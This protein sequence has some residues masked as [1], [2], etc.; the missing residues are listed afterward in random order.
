MDRKKLSRVV[1]LCA[2]AIPALA[3][4]SSHREA[5]FIAGAP[6]VDGTDFYMFR[7]YEPGRSQ[8]VTFIANYNPLQDAYGGPNYFT[9]DPK[10]LYE[11][12]ID[13]NGDARPD[14]TFQFRFLNTYRALTVD[15]G[16]QKVAVPLINIGPVTPAGANLNVIQTYSIELVRGDPRQ[17]EHAPVTNATLG[18]QTFFKPVDNIGMK[19]IANYPAYAANFIYNIA[20]PGCAEQGRVFV[21]QRKDGFVVNL[22]EIFDLVNLNPLGPRDGEPNI[23]S[24]K[25]V[26]SIALEV[27][28]ACLVRGGDPVIGAWTTASLRQG[29]VLN[30]D[31]DRDDADDGVRIH[32]G[33]WTQVSRLGSPLVNEVVIGLPDKNRFNGSEPSHDTQFLTYVT[34]PTLPVLLNALFGSAAMVPGTPRNDLVTIFLTG[35]QGLNQPQH[36]TPAE[37][38]RLNTAIAPTP[39]ASQN[40]LGVLGGD[41]AGFPNGRRPFDDVVDISLRAVMGALC[42]AVGNCGS[43]T[44][45]PNGGRPYTDGARAAGPDAAN[46]HPT[47]AESPNDYYLD[48]FPYLLDPIPGSPNGAPVSP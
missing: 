42:G 16:G 8:F 22:G 10:A 12:R 7:S 20:I 34:N 9:L 45:D 3:L 30:P 4:A 5:P 43:M 48:A 28:I 31:P 40:D 27:P 14:L 35:V 23:I 41:L 19:S 1:A 47:G 29:H 37:M 18:G 46:A 6:K 17:G 36:V 13:N 11:I 33:A 24:D 38:L 39:P 26:T 32:G 44:S 21:G 15:A 25:N 2:A